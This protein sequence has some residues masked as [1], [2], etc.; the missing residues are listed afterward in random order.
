M[1]PDV[2]PSS[3]FRKCAMEFILTSKE[4]STIGILGENC[5]INNLSIS[6]TAFP[7]TLSTENIS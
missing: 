7:G 6:F 4:N 5:F 2:H 1:H 3:L